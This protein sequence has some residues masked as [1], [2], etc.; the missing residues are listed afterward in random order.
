MQKL[1]LFIYLLLYSLCFCQKAFNEDVLNYPQKNKSVY[2]SKF[3]LKEVTEY[4]K[5]KNE[6]SI[7]LQNGYASSELKNTNGWPLK[8]KSYIVKSIRIIF[9]NYPKNKLVWNTNYYE[10][11]SKR[12][13]SI[14]VIDEKLND[15]QIVFELILQNKCET[16]EEAKKLFHG[17]EIVYEL[18]DE[19]KKQIESKDD[20]DLFYD[21]LMNTKVEIDKAELFLKRSL[22]KNDTIVLKSLKE[23][24]ESDSILIV[25]DC[26]GSM[27]PFYSQVSYWASRNFNPTHY[28]VLFH[29]KDIEGKGDTA[30]YIHGRVSSSDEL[31]KM[32]KTATRARGVNREKEEN[33]F[34]SIIKGVKQFF[35]CKKVILVCDNSSCVRDYNLLRFINKPVDVIPCG[36]DHCVNTH[37]MNLAYYTKGTLFWKS[38]KYDIAKTKNNE[39]IE[40][41]GTKYIFYK[42]K[43]F[44][45]K[46]KSLKFTNG[47]CSPM[48][49]PFK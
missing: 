33:D 24:N 20:F 48:F 31:I 47:A 37:Y 34:G 29:D 3:V 1:F 17:I 21:S 27:A 12:L 40:V 26:T 11:I 38:I 19:N 25:I 49:M 36:G 39:T 46:E 4:R 44:V 7:F 10:L 14:F 41:D 6:K 43:G 18:I 22:K 16:E 23:Y 35:N 32:M 2:E 5:N 13:Q 45:F 8:A 42:K 30:R 9:S 28:Y 15:H